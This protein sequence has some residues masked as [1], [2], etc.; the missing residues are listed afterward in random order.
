MAKRIVILIDG[1]FLRAKATKAGKKYDP[2]FIEAFALGCKTGDEEILRV[3]YY[4]CAPYSGTVRLPVS[5]DPFVF[6]GSDK[7]LEE[8]ACKDLFAVRLG[9]LKF[10]GY[11]P[12]RTP[13]D[14]SAKFTD[15]DFDLDFEQKGVDLK[16]GLD[17]ASYCEN[18][19]ADR[20][21][22]VSN[23]TDCVPAVKY[24][25]KS[26]M[27]IVVAE[28]PNCEIARELL[29]HSDFKRSVPWPSHLSWS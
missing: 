10:R 5:G 12:K 19:H 28:L 15:T 27:Q 7:W 24:G 16:I 4:D 25:R 23:D 2:T 17:I 13:V 8:L 20:I 9:V 26:G 6:N 29:I 14:P 18:R 21:V 1:D 22:L 3:L 11:K